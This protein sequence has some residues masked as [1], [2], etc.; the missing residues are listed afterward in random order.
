ML[1]PQFIL[2]FKYYDLQK[3][4]NIPFILDVQDIW[5]DA[6]ILKLNSIIRPLAN[7]LFSLDKFLVKYIMAN[8]SSIVA[9]SNGFLS[10]CQNYGN[11]IG[12]KEDKTFYLGYREKDI[13]I[14]ITDTRLKNL[15]AKKGKNL[16]FTFIGSFGLSYQIELI[17]KV[18]K[19]LSNQKNVKAQFVF[20]GTGENYEYIFNNYSNLKNITLLGWIDETQIQQLLSISDIGLVPCKSDKDTVPNKPFEYLSHGIPLLS[21]LEGEMEK[22]IDDFQIG[23]SYKCDDEDGLFNFVE[24]LINS[25]E[26][27]EKFKVNARKV[28]DENFSTT[29]IYDKYIEHANSIFYASLKS[30]T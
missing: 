9:V 15:F 5:P 13:E 3:K 4:N 26:L 11:R 20:A 24:V 21:S 7:F 19:K 17:C 27:R 22:M 8:S 25:A 16:I 1:F 14:Q 23:F 10:R 2:H 6:I 30:E 28:F 18:A 29:R 12:N